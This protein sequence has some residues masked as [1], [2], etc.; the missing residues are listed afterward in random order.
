[1]ATP[2]ELR[3]SIASGRDTFREAL[4]AASSNW[5][6]KPASGEGEEAWSPRQ[7][8]EHAIPSEIAFV[9][10]VCEACGYPGVTWD[11]STSYAS[12][13]DAIAALDSA[14]ALANGRLKYVSD[15][16]L[17]KKKDET[18]RSCEEWMGINAWHLND[19]AAQITAAD[20]S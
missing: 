15:T 20:S 17:P 5:E 16:D 10:Q 13:E 18:G 14:V 2:D 4:T 12:A 3:A 19:H 1:M 9:N 6:R 8:A 7:A 11:G